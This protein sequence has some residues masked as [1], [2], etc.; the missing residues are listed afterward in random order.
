MKWKFRNICI[1]PAIAS[2][3]TAI[4][5]LLLVSCNSGEADKK[6]TEADVEKEEVMKREEKK[7][8]IFFGNSLT[9][10][11][12]LELNQSF[13]AIIQQ[14]IDSFGLPY[15]VVNAGVSGETSSGG[16]GRMDW[17]L[18]Q[19]PEVF[20]LELGGNDGLRGIPLSE[21]K[22]NLQEIISKVK[23]K[24]PDCKILLAGMQL[25]PNMGRKYTD[26]FSMLFPELANENNIH[27]I[28]FLLENVGGE[29]SLNLEDGIHPNAEGQ[30]LVAENVWK[31]LFPLLTP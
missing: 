29:P 8:I 30:K 26:E 2:Y 17:V 14:K 22:K 1:R 23:N 18:Q 11:Y 13:P 4:T 9:A 24:Y 3:I 27:L 20:V 25:P 10:G 15:T 19:K 31:I 21:T 12:G 16:L 6:S 5:M 28:P 7:L